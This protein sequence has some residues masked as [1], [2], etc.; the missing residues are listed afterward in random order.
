MNDSGGV[1]AVF[2]GLSPLFCEHCQIPLAGVV[3]K[4]AVMHRSLRYALLGEYVQKHLSMI[5]AMDELVEK[6]RRWIQQQID[7]LEAWDEAGRKRWEVVLEETDFLHQ[8]ARTLECELALQ[9]HDT[10]S[11]MPIKKG[12]IP[13]SDG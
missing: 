11:K 12:I 4:L 3:Q 7:A 9:G 6:R 1:E 2:E 8:Y 10:T 5:H 13:S